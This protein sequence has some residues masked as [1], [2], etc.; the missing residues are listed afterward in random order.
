MDFADDIA[1]ISDHIEKARELLLSVERE[2]KKVG[3]GI[4]AGKTKYMQYNI[5]EE[6]EL[7]IADG[8]RIEQAIVEST[9]KQDFKYLGSWVDTTYED[10]R[11]RKGSSWSSMNRMDAI[12]KSNLRRETK[13]RLFRATIES[14]L[15][16]G[17]ETWTL[18]KNL[19]KSIP[20]RPFLRR[21]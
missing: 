1:L 6:I 4:N 16:Y 19:E 18:K 10:M 9:G 3:L 8:T 7:I 11:I 2:C 15:L 12:W 20:Y 21:P 17:C 5:E 13:I 14:V